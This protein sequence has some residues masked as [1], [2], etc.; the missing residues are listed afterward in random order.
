MISLLSYGWVTKICKRA[1]P[2]A[3]PNY[4]FIFLCSLLYLSQNNKS[5]RG[6]LLFLLAIFQISK[7]QLFNF[8]TKSW[9]S[10][11]PS[12]KDR[13]IKLTVRTW[14]MRQGRLG[15]SKDSGLSK[16]PI[17]CLCKDALL[18]LNKLTTKQKIALN[19]TNR[20]GKNKRWNN[21]FMIFPK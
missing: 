3:L 11:A 19:C 17:M 12:T 18:Y 4:H 9:P 10:P 1:D 15:S 20:K 16:L 8:Q 13:K 5:V 2:C 21:H 6:Q 14:S 7:F